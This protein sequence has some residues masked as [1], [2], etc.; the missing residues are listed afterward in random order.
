MQINS[1]KWEQ[2]ARHRRSEV[3]RGAQGFCPSF[4]FDCTRDTG[5]KTL[6]TTRDM[7]DMSGI[8]EEVI[9]VAGEKWEGRCNLDEPTDMP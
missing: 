6:V 4:P 8:I 9:L 2:C 1:R 5:G 7:H 3:V